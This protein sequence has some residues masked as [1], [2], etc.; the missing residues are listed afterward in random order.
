MSA[1]TGVVAL[2]VGGGALEAIGIGLIARQIRR[3]RRRAD[4]L[5]HRDQ[6]VYVGPSVE[7]ERALGGLAVTGGQPPTT[8]DRLDS[9]KHQMLGLRADL[10]E[11]RRKLR[12][13]LRDDIE[14]AENR[15]GRRLGDATSDLRDTLVEILAGSLNERRF[16]VG[17]LLAGITV[18][19]AANVWSLFVTC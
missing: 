2:M 13:E 16:G 12:S 7:H 11:E 8:E 9:L 15:A 1:C 5:L 19:T 18:A 14:R 3:D 6:I 17:V 4:R 10:D